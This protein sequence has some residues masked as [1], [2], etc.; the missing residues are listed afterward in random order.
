MQRF[1]R[2]IGRMS[3]R[4]AQI[5][6]RSI[7][8]LTTIFA[9]LVR[10]GMLSHNFCAIL[11]LLI[12][13]FLAFKTVR[14]NPRSMLTWGLAVGILYL[15]FDGPVCGYLDLH[16]LS[17]LDYRIFPPVF[18]QLESYFDWAV[19]AWEEI[20]LAVGIER[21]PLPYNSQGSIEFQL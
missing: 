12:A 21:P 16:H 5:T 18:P 4:H 19:G 17:R 8:F 11:I 13:C 1:V 10:V 3:R 15:A 6:L 9:V 2:R 7:V 20:Y 14:A